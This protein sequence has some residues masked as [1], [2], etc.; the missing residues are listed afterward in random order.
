MGVMAY[1]NYRLGHV[2]RETSGLMEKY[3]HDV[4][5]LTRILESKT[6]IKDVQAPPTGISM[7]KPG[8]DRKQEFVGEK[9]DRSPM[10]DVMANDALP[11]KAVEAGYFVYETSDNDTL[12]DL[13]ERWY[14]QGRFFPVLIAMNPEGGVFD[15]KAGRRLKILKETDKVGDIMRR[16]VTW[17]GGK[18]YLQYVVRNGDTEESLSKKFYKY[19]DWYPLIREANPDVAIGPGLEIKVPLAPLYWTSRQA[20]ADRK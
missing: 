18:P 4:E 1:E 13:S 20:T 3:H 7:A 9:I 6:A 12:W 16:V 8:E 2:M 19:D 11:R 15:I 17:E 10:P 14:A 5:T